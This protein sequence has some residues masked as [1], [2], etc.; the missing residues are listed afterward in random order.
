MVHERSIPPSEVEGDVSGVEAVSADQQVAIR[1]LLAISQTAG[2]ALYP[3]I[4]E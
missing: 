2:T 1:A 3:L 4:V